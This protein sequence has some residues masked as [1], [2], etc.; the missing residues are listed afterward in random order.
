MNANNGINKLI[1]EEIKA[2]KLFLWLFYIIFITYDLF[3]YFGLPMVNDNYELGFPKEGLGYWVHIIVIGL[4]PVAIYILKHGNAYLAKYLIFIS[5]NLLDFISNLMLYV[6]N[7]V[8]FNSANIVEMFAILFTSLFMSKKYFWVVYGTIAFKYIVYGIVLQDSFLLLGLVILTVLASISF[9]FLS[10]FHS[11]INTMEI[12]NE[13][14]RQKEKLALVG[15]LATSVGHEIR[16]PLASLK[17]FTQLQHEKHPEDKEYYKIMENEIERINL[18][19]DDLM[20]LGRPRTLNI[21]KHKVKEILEYVIAILNPIAQPN[22][23]NICLTIDNGLEIECDGNQIKQVFINLVKN[24]IEAMPMGG[25]LTITSNIIND[26]EMVIYIQ[27]EGNG[28]EKLDLLGQPFFTTK[29]DGNGLGLMVT[30]NIVE[31]HNGRI[32]FNSGLG[33]GTT[34]ELNLPVQYSKRT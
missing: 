8:P 18:I 25:N 5:Y 30:F 26:G 22:N 33:K 27:D 7:D 2:T 13:D 14:L 21:E 34:V 17:G 28:I 1:S 6:G 31:K 29:Q 19:V 15:Q 23:V 4:L 12:V 9:L 11:Y 10:R 20:Y 3:Y 16:N 24:A 32:T